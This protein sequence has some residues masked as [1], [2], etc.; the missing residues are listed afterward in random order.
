VNNLTLFTINSSTYVTDSGAA[1][2]IAIFW[3]FETF[4]IEAGMS[5]HSAM[6]AK[7][8]WT[9]KCP[10]PMVGLP[11]W[12]VASKKQVEIEVTHP[13]LCTNNYTEQNNKTVF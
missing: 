4:E 10:P 2:S 7:H 11:G 9:G 6:R 1:P 8:S 3:H 5:F 12:L 13:T